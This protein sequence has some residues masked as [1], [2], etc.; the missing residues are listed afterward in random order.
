MEVYTNPN[1]DTVLNLMNECGVYLSTQTNE[2]FG[3][4]IVEALSLGCIP[5]IYRDGGPWMDIFEEQEETGLAY[6]TTE[7]AITKIKRILEDEE[8]RAR[9]RDNGIER[10]KAFT[11]KN[12]RA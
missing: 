3:M 1:R 2:A 6:T 9:L 11:A 10:A 12:F 7:E 4:A 8:L 5:V